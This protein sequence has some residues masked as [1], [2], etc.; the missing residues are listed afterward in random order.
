MQ[1]AKSGKIDLIPSNFYK[2]RPFQTGKDIE[3]AEQIICQHQIYFPP[4]I[5]FND[6][7]DCRPSFTF[8]ATRNE[9]VADYIQLSR[10]YG[11]GFGR[12]KIRQDIRDMFADPERD[13]RRPIAQ[14][15]MRD[16][17]TEHI[18]KKVGVLCVSTV[19]DDILMWSHY[20]DCHK[21]ICIEFDGANEFMAGAQEVQY[22]PER[23]AINP[24]RDDKA[25]SLE[26]ALL[27][28][29]DH[30]KYEKEWRL[31]Q[32]EKGPGTVTFLPENVT[33]IIFGAHVE[34]ATVER[35][36]GWI[37]ARVSPVKLYQAR[38]DRQIFKIHI[39]QV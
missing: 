3:R 34:R 14:A 9:M 35:V 29:S 2:Y 21:G 18:T 13:P 7:F 26:K 15:R 32:Y 6:P 25:T 30:W 22:A 39:E 31:I 23:K 36:S 16:S 19:N 4:P 28:K 33:G 5:S 37:K 10:K 20:A 17:H 11:S 38:V 12:K 1:I 8:E 24:Y 27:T